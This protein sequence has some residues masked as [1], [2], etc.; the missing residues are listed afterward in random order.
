LAL[1]PARTPLIIHTMVPA[2]P[3]WILVGQPL[4]QP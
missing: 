1:N 2:T 3:V 4:I